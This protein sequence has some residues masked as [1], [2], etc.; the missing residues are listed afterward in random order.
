MQNLSLDALSSAFPH[1]KL[2]PAE[3]HGRPYHLPN[4]RPLRPWLFP[5]APRSWRQSTASACPKGT[6][7]WC[8]EREAMSWR[9]TRGFPVWC[10]APGRCAAFSGCPGAHCSRVRRTPLAPCHLCPGAGAHRA[11]VC[12]R[13]PRLGGRRPLYERRRLWRRAQGRGGE[14]Q[15]TAARRHNLGGRGRPAG[16]C[17]P[18][19]RLPEAG[20]R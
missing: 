19:Q 13:D 1:L 4:R 9:L 3:A 10:S 16:L 17:L 5:K 11:G 6:G 12:P 18:H 20:P 14:D 2:I 15:G 8:W 7:R